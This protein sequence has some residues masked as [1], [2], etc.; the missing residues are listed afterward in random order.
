[1]KIG[2]STDF[3]V[4]DGDG[5]A[6][7]Q[8]KRVERASEQWVV[9]VWSQPGRKP[10]SMRTWRYVLSRNE[11]FDRLGRTTVPAHPAKRPTL[12]E[13]LAL[14]ELAA[15]TVVTARPRKGGKP[16]AKV[17]K[18]ATPE[19]PAGRYVELD[20]SGDEADGIPPALAVGGADVTWSSRTRGIVGTPPEVPRLPK[21][22]KL[23]YQY[24]T[25][26][27]SAK[28]KED[29][30]KAPS[31][32]EDEGTTP[33]R[34]PSI[35]PEGSVRAGE[36]IALVVD[37]LREESATTVGATMLPPQASDWKE[38][39]V[40][41][42]LQSPDIDFDDG[43]RGTL[44]VRRNDATLVARITGRVYSGLTS[45]SE[46]QVK[47]K[48][49]LG[50]RFCGSAARRLVV[51]GKP[52]TKASAEPAQ[53]T[54]QFDEAA[55]QPDLTVFISLFDRD[56]P[57]RLHW[58]MVTAPFAGCPPKLDGLINLGQKPDEEA[59]KLFKRFANLERGHH[60]E[61]IEGFGEEL[62]RRAPPEFQAVYWAVS[63]YRRRPLTIQFVSDDPH[64]PWELMSPYR[65]GETHGPI[66]LR[67][68]VARWIGS[69]AGYMRN[70]LPKGSLVAIAPRY[71]SARTQLS[72]AEAAAQELVDKLGAQRLGA[73]RQKLLQLLEQPPEKP[74][75]LV[76]FTGHGAFD[77]DAAGASEIKLE[78][79]A[80]L[81][82][83]EV[84][85]Q[86]VTLGERYGTVV[87]LNA[88]E[89]GATASVLGNVGGWADAFLSRKF[90]AFIAPLWAI[91]EE[92]A[93][94]VTQEL[95]H[96]IVTQCQPIGA[97]LRDVRAK[98]GA[99]SPTFYSYLLYGDVTARL[100]TA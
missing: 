11:F 58:R 47:A 22:R 75:A 16:G 24:M 3:I 28:T 72:L 66:A 5:P 14:S 88:C 15:S 37:L 85:R 59:T 73:T 70:R 89:V 39:K 65:D 71:K 31:A 12:A 90:G 91:D 25:G 6:L 26:V 67:H 4:L 80:N 23:A 42:A 9:I 69:W 53:A 17:S 64:L 41:V 34:Y 52:V 61:A 19:G 20:T 83:R 38:L 94:Q 68:A 49:L 63:D 62:W 84:A 35:E 76:Y 45:G 36:A 100:G 60:R 95:M 98:Y 81:S 8:I 30:A 27:P 2:W 55:T 82:A 44:T 21:L 92:D 13:V 43:G 54:V 97:A 93:K 77:A 32:V 96:A 48:F 40:E 51:G 79:G 10:L 57:G 99:V 56:A 29:E 7:A 50:T 1:M 78:E 74:V 86:K 33:V 46:I 18:S 87:F